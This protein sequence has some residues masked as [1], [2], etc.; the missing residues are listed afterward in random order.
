MTHGAAGRV[1]IG[2]VRG[3][4]VIFHELRGAYT[5]DIRR[6]GDVPRDGDRLSWVN[7]LSRYV[8][9][10]LGD[11]GRYRAVRW[12][13]GARRGPR[14]I[15]YRNISCFFLSFPLS[16]IQ[17]VFFPFLPSSPTRDYSTGW[18]FCLRYTWRGPNPDAVIRE[19]KKRSPLDLEHPE[20]RELDSS[21]PTG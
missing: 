16:I 18:R 15:F 8:P 17:R 10:P 9:R 20:P 3:G 2:V 7:W 6:P 11:G 14:R 12:T 13:R 4:V 5:R 21:S 1:I 19:K